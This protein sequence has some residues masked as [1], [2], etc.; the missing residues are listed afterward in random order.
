MPVTR[1]FPLDRKQVQSDAKPEIAGASAF[2]STI[3]TVI[4]GL[5]DETS[6]SKRAAGGI[7]TTRA[8]SKATTRSKAT[9]SS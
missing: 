5:E 7:R 9:S 4:A 8:F 3:A 6:L 2:L 1:A